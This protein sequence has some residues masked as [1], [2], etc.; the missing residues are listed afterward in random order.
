MSTS[1][2]FDWRPLDEAMPRLVEGSLTPVSGEAE[3]VAASVEGSPA[4]R[5][6]AWL[7]VDDLERAH[8]VCQDD[9]SEMG[10]LLHAIV[11]RREGD[12]GNARYWLMRAGSLADPESRS[13]V[14]DVKKSRGDEPKLLARQREEWRK[15]WEKA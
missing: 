13:L 1:P 5:A 9:L 11:H 10:S 3:R 14:D 8:Q 6:L 12:F 4:R 7:Y 15:L 2:L